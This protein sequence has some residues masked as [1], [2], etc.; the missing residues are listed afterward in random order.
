MADQEIGI[1]G[2]PTR[3]DVS[4]DVFGE[5]Y[6]IKDTATILDPSVIIFN[7]SGAKDGLRGVFQVP[8]DYVGTP[9]CRVYWTGNATTG[10]TIWDWTV[11]ARALGEDMGAAAQRTSETVTDA[12]TGTAFVLEIAEITLTAADYA[13][14]DIV[15]FELFRDGVSEG[16]GGMAVAAIVFW[17][18]FKYSDA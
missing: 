9:R 13:K 7:D 1:L 18:T 17:V 2:M 10:N 5:P 4:G 6:S 15:L 14:G 16:G 12:K 3:P 11:L 8:Q